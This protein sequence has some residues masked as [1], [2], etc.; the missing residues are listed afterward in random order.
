LP[1]NRKPSPAAVKDDPSRPLVPVSWGELFDKIAILEIKAERIKARAALAN[2]R[3]ELGALNAGAALP[4]RAGLARLR[5]AL[6]QVNE[7]LWEIED[8]IRA[9]E[10]KQTFDAGFIALARS[11]YRTNDRRAEIKRKIND[12]LGSALV[13][14]KHYA[15]Y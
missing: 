10:G 6:R 15:R 11:V 1:R 3:R 14:E 2:V 13:E 8:K 9:K 7:A 12:L 4:R 5:R